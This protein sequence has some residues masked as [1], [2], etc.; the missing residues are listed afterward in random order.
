MLDVKS[1]TKG[2]LAPR[3]TFAQRD[4]IAN[5]ATG[6]LVFCTENNSFFSNKGTPVLP[7]WIMVNTQWL[8][9][10]S[11]IAY[12]LGNV[13]IGTTS[14]DVKLEVAGKI[15]ADFGTSSSASFVFGSGQE[16]TGFSSPQVNAVNVITNGV[17]RARF[18]G[19][20]ALGI[21]TSAPGSSAILDIAST[22]K[23]ILPP[24]MTYVQRNAI[25]SPAEGLIVFCTN[26]R[27]DGT[28]CISLYFGGQWL[29]LA[30]NC[31]LP[32][33]PVEGS[34]VQ[35]N[36]QIIWNWSAVPIAD[37]YKWHTSNNF[38]AATN[39]GT[40]TTKT[41]TG[42]TQGTSYTR[43]VWA[44]NACGNTEP[45]IL[46]GQALTC[47]SSFTET[48]TAGTVA[49]VT[50]TVTY[51]TV[52]NIPGEIA[53]CWITRN[54]G[55]SQQPTAVDDGTEASAGWYWQFNHKQGYKHDGTTRT[56]NT[57]WITSIIEDAD[58]QADKD[59]CSLLL[60]PEW[61]IP[62]FTEWTNV[63][64]AGMW[65]NWND[66]F[67]SGL[68]MHAAGFLDFILNGS[69]GNRGSLGIYR[70]RSQVFAGNGSSLAISSAVSSM[71]TDT[72][73]DGCSVRCLR[74]N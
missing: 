7:L 9:T 49:P 73:A 34:H 70:S 55:A 66:V 48:H 42:L 5:P 30:G 44:Y 53:K 40:A 43:Y 29:N 21:G 18:T 50:K 54:L 69:L 15:A 51:G 2:T 64:A 28:G 46:F 74:G 37:G 71:Y 56:P 38:A 19:A 65:V 16:N 32:A 52:T 14:P 58:W 10:G 13:G 72:K 41:E 27:V 45:V 25:V 3:M 61:R 8:N 35:T 1:T 12:S 4:A 39:M 24:R 59:P 47:G 23:G 11:N 33:V 17:E 63:D 36:T 26:C 22:T 60:G 31:E 6:L 68:R 62:T 20:G 57:T 67:S